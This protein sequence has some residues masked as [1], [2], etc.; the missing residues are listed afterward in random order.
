MNLKISNILEIKK[1]NLI[2]NFDT[3]I[4]KIIYFYK[5]YFCSMNILYQYMGYGEGVSGVYLGFLALMVSPI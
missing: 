3:R 4:Y 2:E 5:L 1:P